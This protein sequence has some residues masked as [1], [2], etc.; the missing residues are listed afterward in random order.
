MK[1]SIIRKVHVTKN[2]EIHR[3]FTNLK[4]NKLQI[5][6][7]KFLRTQHKILK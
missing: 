7:F 2:K 6:G 3:T 1:A 4:W 5:R